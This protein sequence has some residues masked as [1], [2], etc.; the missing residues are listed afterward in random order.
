MNPPVDSIFRW[1]C[2]CTDHSFVN[3]TEHLAGSEYQTAKEAS[4]KIKDED[5]A[6]AWDLGHTGYPGPP[7]QKK[8]FG[9]YGKYDNEWNLECGEWDDTREDLVGCA[10]IMDFDWERYADEE[11][12]FVDENILPVLE[13]DICEMLA[14]C[15]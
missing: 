8:I 15:K 5:G 6:I 12:D 1:S 2:F 7:M 11:T 9:L 13:D 14:S 3:E 10:T 4:S